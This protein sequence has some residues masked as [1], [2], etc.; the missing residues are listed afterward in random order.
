M[1]RTCTYDNPTARP[2]AQAE[3][4]NPPIVLPGNAAPQQSLSEDEYIDP[5]N[6]LIYCAKCHTPR[7]GRYHLQLIGR[8]MMPRFLCKCQSEERKAAEEK[9]MRQEH[10]AKVSRLRASGLQ[11]RFLHD[12][13]FEKDTMHCPELA[14]AH[15]YVENWDSLKK[16][17]Q[18]LLL[19]G[20]VGTGKTF[21]AGCIANALIDRCIP[22]LMIEIPNFLS[23]LAGMPPSERNQFIE[24]FNE[25]SL[26]ILDDLGVERNSEYAAEQVFRLVDS[27]Y[28]SKNPLIVTTNLTL[29]EMKKPADLAHERIFGRILEN[30]SP[31]LMNGPNL[32]E[33]KAAENLKMVSSF[34]CKTNPA[35]P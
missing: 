30:C 21:F 28:R 32:R 35:V 20:P 5:E 3:R 6:G 19:W 18:G 12:C 29:D 9:R 24:S 2:D 13:R 8:D 17:G 22:V 1:T 7:Q 25:Y 27:R 4:L 14:K 10:M 23:E 11:N 34:L 16:K 31:L 15:A 33:Q 26:L